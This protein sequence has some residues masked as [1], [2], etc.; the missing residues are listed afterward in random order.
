[1][2]IRGLL[3][4]FGKQAGEP[5]DSSKG[6]SCVTYAHGRGI[7]LMTGNGDTWLAPKHTTNGVPVAIRSGAYPVPNTHDTTN[8]KETGKFNHET[9]NTNNA[10]MRL[11]TARPGLAQGGD[12]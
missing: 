9:N 3:T 11:P 8:L 12:L 7:I 10:T 2:I 6:K 1:M 4:F 5:E